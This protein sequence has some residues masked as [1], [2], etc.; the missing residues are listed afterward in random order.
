[1]MMPATIMLPAMMVM[2]MAVMIHAV[3]EMPTMMV[4]VVMV[5]VVAAVNAVHVDTLQLA[6]TLAG[7]RWSAHSPLTETAALTLPPEFLA[8][9]HADPGKTSG[10]WFLLNY[11]FFTLSIR[12]FRKFSETL[13]APFR[14]PET[15]CTRGRLRQANCPRPRFRPGHAGSAHIPFSTVFPSLSYTEWPSHLCP[16]C[17]AQILWHARV[18]GQ[19][20][21]FQHAT[22]PF[23]EGGLGCQPI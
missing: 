23:P 22:P 12:I 6:S 7:L 8:S 17:C 2:M 21:H 20:V 9:F 15:P 18:A 19:A 1:M 13:P 16:D 3:L 10:C 4:M 11:R 5:M 14:P